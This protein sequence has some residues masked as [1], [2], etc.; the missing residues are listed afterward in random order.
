[1]IPVLVLLAGPNGAGKSTL[2]ETRVRPAIAAPFVNADLIQRDELRDPDPD[3]AYAAARIAAERRAAHLAAGRSFVA[4]TVFSHPSKL[5]LIDDARARG[6]TVIVFHVGVEAADLSVARV[7]ARVSEGGHPVPEAK[8]RARFD[9]TG[10]LIRE[11]VR[12]ADRGLV[13]DNS[14]LNVPPAHMLTLTGGRTTFVAPRL[15][16]WVRDLYAEDIAGG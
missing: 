14:A 2:Y 11:A 10:P 12:R 5:D 6:F 13:F 9:R 16:R 15:R 8:V 1:M 3:A 7:A 4:E